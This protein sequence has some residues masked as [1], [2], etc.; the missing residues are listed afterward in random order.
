MKMDSGVNAVRLN[1]PVVTLCRFSERQEIMQMRRKDND[2]RDT[3][4]GDY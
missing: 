3:S 4:S 1:L 2:Q